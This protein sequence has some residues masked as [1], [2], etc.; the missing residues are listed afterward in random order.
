MSLKLGV[1]IGVPF[2]DQRRGSAFSPD[3]DSALRYWGDASGRAVQT[4]FTNTAGTTPATTDGAAIARLNDRGP[5]GY[6]ATQ[7]TSG[8]RPALRL[9]VQNGLDM[10]EGDGSNDYLDYVGAVASATAM[11]VYVVARVI[12][13]SFPGPS[14]SLDTIFSTGDSGNVSYLSLIHI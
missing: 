14:N 10:I 5:Y 1:G 3:Q 13:T 2:G 6:N 4:L 7:A 12:R 8:S 11:T 9:G